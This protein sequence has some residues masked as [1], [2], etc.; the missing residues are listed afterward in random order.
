MGRLFIVEGLDG[1]GKT[2]LVNHMYEQATSP[3]AM[4]HA[5][6]P[7]GR[8]YVDEYWFPI[9]FLGQYD[10]ICDRWHLG[11]HVWPIL[12]GRE[13]LT[14]HNGITLLENRMF[15][16]FDEVYGTMLVRDEEGMRSCRHLDYEPA[17]AI[18]LYDEAMKYSQIDWEI[19]TLDSIMIGIG[20]APS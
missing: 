9:C 18:A 7:I 14:K 3:K 4:F 16:M 12:F 8:D 2:T 5:T 6:K 17:D 15:T 11:E 19:T 1:V 13:P 20:D 10:V